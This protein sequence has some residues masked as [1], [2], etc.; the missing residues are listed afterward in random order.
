MHAVAFGYTGWVVQVGLS[1]L[2][3]EKVP[4]GPIAHAVKYNSSTDMKEMVGA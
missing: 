2:T 3:C 1:E 4:D